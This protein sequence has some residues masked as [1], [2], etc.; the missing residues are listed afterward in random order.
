MNRHTW[1]AVENSGIICRDY[2]CSVPRRNQNGDAAFWAVAKMSETSTESRQNN[3]A[4]GKLDEATDEAEY[5]EAAMA[6][7]NM[8]KKMRRLAP[9]FTDKHA[10]TESIDS[11]VPDAGTRDLEPCTRCNSLGADYQSQPSSRVVGSDKLDEAQTRVNTEATPFSSTINVDAEKFVNPNLGSKTGCGD[12]GCPPADAR[13]TR[14]VTRVAYTGS[15]S[16]YENGE[17]GIF[18]NCPDAVAGPSSLCHRSVVF[19][20]PLAAF[21]CPVKDV[22][23]AVCQWLDSSFP[24]V[25]VTGWTGGEWSLWNRDTGAAVSSTFVQSCYSAVTLSSD[26]DCDRETES[27]PSSVSNDVN[28]VISLS[29]SFPARE[30]PSL[31]RCTV[32]T[33]L[34]SS[35]DAPT[36]SRTSVEDLQLLQPLSLGLYG[37]T[38]ARFTSAASLTE[39]VLFRLNASTALYVAGLCRDDEAKQRVLCLCAKTRRTGITEDLAADMRNIACA[40]VEGK[41]VLWK[42]LTCVLR[43][44]ARVCWVAPEAGIGAGVKIQEIRLPESHRNRDTGA[45]V[46]TTIVQPCY[47]AVTLSSDLECDRET[48][49]FPSSVSNDIN[50][51]ISLSESFP[52]QETP[53]LARCTVATALPS[54]LDAPTTSRT[55]VEDLQLLQP[56]SLGLYGETEARFTSAASLT[57]E[58]LFRLNASTALYVAGLCRDDEAKERVLC[59][60]AQARRTGITEDLAAD[61]RNIACAAVE[62]KRVLWKDLTCVLRRLARVC[63]VAPE[64]GIGAGVNIQEIRLPESHRNV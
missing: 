38:E 4:T 23:A 19:P 12:T 49:S 8:L 59:L 36:T 46:S 21:V 32:A 56:L 30:T 42:D 50:G 52:A 15:T 22:T 58:V 64:A 61:M 1:G 51:V 9:R 26:L 34:P 20:D 11:H 18:D 2:Q 33:A 3:G 55:S 47:S 44:L 5:R 14:P 35:L 6:V 62:G 13:R 7:E 60:C 29:K 53:S 17:G 57:E 16:H 43:R 39:E 37:E 45:A 28:G 24:D 48:E 31:A 40:A 63:W 54:S 27:F 25:V 10:R 41:R